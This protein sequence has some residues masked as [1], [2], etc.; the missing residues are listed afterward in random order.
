MVVIGTGLRQTLA[1]ALVGILQVV[2]A[3]KTDVDLLRGL[4]ASFEEG[5]PGSQRRR[6]ADRLT[7]L[8]QDGGV[9]SLVLHVDRHLIDAR[10]VLTLDDTVE[11]DITEGS[12][13]LADGVV[14]MLLRPEHEHVRLD[15]DALQ[16]LDAVLCRLG[17]QFACGPEIRH[18]SQVDVDG[19]ATEFPFQLTDGLHERCALDV[20]NG[21][22]NLRDDEIVMI[23]LSEEFDVTL[24]FIRDMR[25]DLYGLA[26]VVAST[27]LVNDRLVDTAR[28]HRVGL[29]GLDAS[30][31]LIMAQV[32]VRLHAIN[33]DI[34]LSMLIG[35]E[36]ARINVDVRV[37]LLDGDVVTSCLKKF[38]NGR[39]D[40]A[41]A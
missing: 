25:D 38:T 7:D 5:F 35:I 11:V 31:A 39:R 40:D 6:L 16:L 21:T 18:E 34:A 29:S 23:F 36:G 41:L 2:F 32:K 4:L 13:L 15:A 9:Q 37:K 28:R 3:D 33:G 8:L 26:E 17:L 20:T 1:D 22:S 19:P 12:D 27:L 10:Q 30:E 14:E 24:D